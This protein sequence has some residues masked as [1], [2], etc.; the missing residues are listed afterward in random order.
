MEYTGVE[1]LEIMSA[2]ENYNAFLLNSVL[3][4]SANA[5]TLLDFGAGLGE[6]AKKIR[7]RGFEVQCFEV[8]P[9]LSERLRS[10]GFTVY[11]NE[12]SVPRASIDQVYTLNVLEHVK[13]DRRALRSFHQWIRPGGK[14]FIYVPALMHLYT[15]MDKQVG[16]VRR[17]GRA[18]L[19]EKVREAGFQNIDCRFVDS[20][21]YFATLAF[22]FFGNNEGKIP[23]KGVRI[24]DRYLFPLSRV[25]DRA[26]GK[27]GGKNLLLTADRE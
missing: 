18:E 9:G 3:T 16:H 27:L 4:H 21:G 23:G 2:A 22:K 13:D 5:K 26:A 7:G 11:S 20:V 12:D 14:L 10:E 19:I 17:Y 8:D 1:N 15:S 24:Y 6:F 25:L